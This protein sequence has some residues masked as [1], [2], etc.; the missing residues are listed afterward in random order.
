M[1]DQQTQAQPTSQVQEPVVPVA[2]NQEEVPAVEKPV[3]PET[4]ATPVEPA[5]PVTPGAE[6]VQ[7]G[8]E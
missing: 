5:A 8:N 7:P 3:V 6:E 4:P 2:D 1:D